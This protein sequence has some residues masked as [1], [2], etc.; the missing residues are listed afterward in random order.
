ME[1]LVD[2]GG[3]DLLLLLKSGRRLPIVGVSEAH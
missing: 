2:N 1:A 3:V